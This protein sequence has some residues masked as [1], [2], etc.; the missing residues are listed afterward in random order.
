MT[1]MPMPT[2]S[3]PIT[4]WR[5]QTY[6]DASDNGNQIKKQRYRQQQPQ[7][8][9]SIETEAPSSNPVSTPPSTLT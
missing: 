4:T 5:S 2:E 9:E 1:T 7:C 3:N 6:S 8:Y